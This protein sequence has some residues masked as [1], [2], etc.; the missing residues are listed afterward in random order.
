M[1]KKNVIEPGDGQAP[2]FEV[3]YRELEEIVTQLERGDLPLEEA[4][5]LHERGQELAT[6]CARQ[7]DQAELRVKK[8][9]IDQENRE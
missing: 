4:L 5:K 2:S 8:L 6:Y 3:A 1:P 9:E 7:L